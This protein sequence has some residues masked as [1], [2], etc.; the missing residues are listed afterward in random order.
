LHL[1][2]AS[3]GFA[4]ACLLSLGL[5]PLVRRLATRKGLRDLPSPRKIHTAARPHIG[6][7]AIL[8][9]VVAAL[10]ATA[11][12]F[13]DLSSDYFRLVAG[14]VPAS[15][16]VAVLGLIDDIQGSRPWKKLATQGIALALLQLHVDVLSLSGASGFSGL[17]RVVVVALALP[18]FLGLTN[19][20]NLI[21]GLDGLASGIAAIAGLGL[22]GVAWILGQPVVAI[23]AAVL[24]GAAL[25]FLRSN[26]HPAKIFMGDTG[27]MFLGFLLAA[28]GARLFQGRPDLSTFLALLMIA[29]VPALDALYALVRR[30]ARN[31]SIFHADRGHLHHRLLDVG[32]SQRHAGLSLCGLAA[33]GATAGVQIAQDRHPWT[34]AGAVLLATLPL[35]WILRLR[36]ERPAPA[37]GGGSRATGART[38]AEGT[39]SQEQAA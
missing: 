5:T 4:V 24:V 13:P 12:A 8:G 27:S 35:G 18:W 9:A 2:A 20:M 3:F 28:L 10:L 16:L 7:L 17:T 33:L 23:V 19:A 6:G 1:P 34:W 21:D 39:V 37:V 32:F 14:I 15:A 29:W 11:V 36:P 25:G 26:V 22:I 38:L 31:E 30:W